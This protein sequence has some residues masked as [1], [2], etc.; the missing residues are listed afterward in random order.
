[1]WHLIPGA[2]RSLGAFLAGALIGLLASLGLDIG[3][4]GAVGLENF[5]TA[6]LTGLVAYIAW[7]LGIKLPDRAPEE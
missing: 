3:P 1:M 5:L 2:L 6:L 7:K 4:E